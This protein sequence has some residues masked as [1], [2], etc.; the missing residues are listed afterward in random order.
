MNL[1]FP[2]CGKNKGHILCQNGL[3]PFI[4][5]APHNLSQHQRSRQVK[6]VFVCFLLLSGFFYESPQKQILMH[7]QLCRPVTLCCPEGVVSVLSTFCLNPYESKQSALRLM[8]VSLKPLE[9][10]RIAAAS[11]ICF[12]CH[13]T[14]GSVTVISSNLLCCFQCVECKRDPFSIFRGYCSSCLPHIQ[15]QCFSPLYANTLQ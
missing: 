10:T 8:F 15:S 4:Q 12:A 13:Q 5:V 9:K 6:L 3:H 1:Y 11:S 7:V 2:H 14:F